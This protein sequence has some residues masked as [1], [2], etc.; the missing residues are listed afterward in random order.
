VSSGIPCAPWKR[1]RRDALV[2]LVI[3]CSSPSFRTPI[4]GGGESDSPTDLASR[5]RELAPAELSSLY[6]GDCPGIV[7]AQKSG[8]QMRTALSGT[9]IIRHPVHSAVV[10]DGGER[11]LKTRRCTAFPRTSY[12][13]VAIASSGSHRTGTRHGRNHPTGIRGG[14][15]ASFHGDARRR[16]Q[17]KVCAPAVGPLAAFPSPPGQVSVECLPRIPSWSSSRPAGGQGERAHASSHRRS[18]VPR[19]GGN[20]SITMR[21]CVRG[22]PRVVSGGGCRE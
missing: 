1:A 3:P 12:G 4:C 22:G 10:C 21:Q 6:R 14:A 11:F 7:R 8:G 16:W 13:P 18:G 5:P 2:P 17:K 9:S 19:I 15:L 20:H